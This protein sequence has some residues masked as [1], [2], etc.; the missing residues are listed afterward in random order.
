MLVTIRNLKDGFK[1]LEANYFNLPQNGFRDEYVKQYGQDAWD[2]RQK[3]LVDDVV[4]REQH[5]EKLRRDLS[6]K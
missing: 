1:E 2:K 3:L 6:S 5:F 4:S